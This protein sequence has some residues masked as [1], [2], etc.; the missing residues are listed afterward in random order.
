[1]KK[2]EKIVRVTLEEAL[3]LKSASDLKKMRS[4]TDE[5]ISRQIA[6]DPDLYELTDEEISEFRKPYGKD[7]EKPN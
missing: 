7:D 5:E 2:K 4:T 3:K 6:N 1:M